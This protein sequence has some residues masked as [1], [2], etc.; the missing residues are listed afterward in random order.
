MSLKTNN[1][2]KSG[3]IVLSIILLT[4]ISLVSTL[5][6]KVQGQVQNSP[7]PP[8]PGTTAPPASSAAPPSPGG[9]PSSGSTAPPPLAPESPGGSP[10]SGSTAPPPLAPES[11]GGSPS[12]GSTAPPASSVA[13]PSPGG[14][15]S[16]GSTAPPPLA[17]ESPGGSPSSGSTAPPLTTPPD[18]DTADGGQA[19]NQTGEGG[20]AGNQSAVVMIPLTT[21]QMIMS[22]LQDAVTAI[23][24]NNKDNAT[25]AM[26]SVDQELKSA[27]NASGITIETSTGE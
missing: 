9:S 8:T 27:A 24:S 14:S 17:P 15:P 13:P 26:N 5:E 16:S 10:S 6:I 25:K 18:L 12:S 11:P 22:Q 7:A 19:A 23:D 1:L 3:V 2:T 21:M 4:G 20:G